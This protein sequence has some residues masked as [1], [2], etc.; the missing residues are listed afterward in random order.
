M[1]RMHVL[2]WKAEMSKI[3]ALA[4]P[5]QRVPE[6]AEVVVMD[7]LGTTVSYQVY[8]VFGRHTVFSGQCTMSRGHCDGTATGQ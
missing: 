5:L 3:E 2:S 1:S 7:V 4:S 6:E 8:S